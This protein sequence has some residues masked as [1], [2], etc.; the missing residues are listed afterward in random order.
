M[1]PDGA[2]VTDDSHQ[3]V[4]PPAGVQAFVVLEEW[5]EPVEED[6]EA[7]RSASRVA[8]S[9]PIP[10]AV[11]LEHR[12]PTVDLAFEELEVMAEGRRVVQGDGGGA[13]GE[14]LECAQR[15]RAIVEDMELELIGLMAVRNDRGDG[16][17]GGAL[18]DGSPT[19]D[20]EKAGA[21]EVDVMDRLAAF[22]RS[23]MTTDG[24]QRWRVGR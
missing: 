4:G 13:M 11:L 1:D 21:I 10:R 2:A 6:D 14:R 3:E 22:G 18:A 19:G 5:T 24:H 20:E 8:Q 23:V 7:G 9:G 12:S 16:H 17:E 15:A